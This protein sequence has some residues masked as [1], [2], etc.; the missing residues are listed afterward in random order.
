MRNGIFNWLMGVV[1]VALLIGCPCCKKQDDKGKDAPKTNKSTAIV[2]NFDP[3]V[4]IP[5][6][7][8]NSWTYK[9]TGHKNYFAVNY[10]MDM[11]TNEVVDVRVL[12]N[13]IE[14]SYS[15]EE[16]YTITGYNPEI[17]GYNFEVNTCNVMH[18]ARDG[19]YLKA[20]SLT[21]KWILYPEAESTA[22]VFLEKI[23]YDSSA[24]LNK[25]SGG[26]YNLQPNP[27]YD[28]RIEM[29]FRKSNGKLEN[30]SKQMV[31]DSR[32]V[33]SLCD[34]YDHQISVP[35]G[36][37][38]ECIECLQAYVL[39]DEQ[40]NTNVFVIHTFWAP[41]VGKVMEFYEDSVKEIAYTMELVAYDVD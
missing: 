35:A 12:T 2:K 29:L 11:K 28:E 39:K 23:D 30:L 10:E 41:N 14:K 38:N 17:E 6:E 13:R 32:G 7:V 22:Y 25:L 34:L 24:K 5:L 36:V 40:E 15:C 8:G 16:V 26:A 31:L 20:E 27:Q 21:W 33:G 1:V 37:F 9:W 18:F 4:Y 19:R 3:R